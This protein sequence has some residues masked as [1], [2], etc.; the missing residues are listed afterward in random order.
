MNDQEIQALLDRLSSASEGEYQAG[1]SANTRRLLRELRILLERVA[2]ETGRSTLS[3]SEADLD[4]L[5]GKLADRLHQVNTAHSAY[6]FF[7]WFLQRKGR[8]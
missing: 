1:S 3:V 4:V 2:E 6:R 8:R 5:A 7:R